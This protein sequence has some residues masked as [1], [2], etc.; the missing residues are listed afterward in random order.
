MLRRMQFGLAGFYFGAGLHNRETHGFPNPSST[1]N[2]FPDSQWEAAHK[3]L[4]LSRLP[5]SNRGPS[6][7]KR[8]ALPTEL[9]R[10]RHIVPVFLLLFKRESQNV[11]EHS[12]IR[13]LPF[14]FLCSL[15][16]F[17]N[18]DFVSRRSKLR[19]W[20][21]ESASLCACTPNQCARCP[22]STAIPCRI[23]WAACIRNGGT[24]SISF[25]PASKSSFRCSA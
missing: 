8:V 16:F 7:Y 4:F 24:F 18:S 17:K 22:A 20:E 12:A 6:L 23:R 2:S 5:D 21:T 10:R 14:P 1:G 3:N 11:L 15:T 13:L 25:Q 9:R 19:L